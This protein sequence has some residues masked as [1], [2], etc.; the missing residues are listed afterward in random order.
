MDRVFD[1]TGAL[2][3]ALAFGTGAFVS[4]VLAPMVFRVLEPAAASRFL[5]A[6]FPRYYAFLLA[7][8][9]GVGLAALGRPGLLPAAAVLAALAAASLALV[10]RINA[11]RDK[12]PAGARQFRR[13]HGLSVLLNLAMLAASG[14]LVA[15]YVA[16]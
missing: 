12:G 1:T 11:A 8:G 9:A 6:M 13:L 10:P 3:A 15:G 4:F 16:G 14:W 7:C 2:L 5:R